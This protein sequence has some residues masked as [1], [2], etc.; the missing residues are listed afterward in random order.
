MVKARCLAEII[1][2]SNGKKKLNLTY[3]Y[4]NDIK[5]RR[6][7]VMCFKEQKRDDLNENQTITVY[8]SGSQTL[9]QAILGKYRKKR[10]HKMPEMHHHQGQIFNV[11]WVHLGTIIQAFK[12]QWKSIRHLEHSSKKPH[13][14]KKYHILTEDYHHLLPFGDPKFEIKMWGKSLYN[15]KCGSK[16]MDSELSDQILTRGLHKRMENPVFRSNGNGK[17]G[18]KGGSMETGE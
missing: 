2:N 17:K 13:R 9:R 10:R 3:N 5:F 11:I 15:R 14:G 1:S 12:S 4:L 18:F 6:Q 8:E 7:L 16:L